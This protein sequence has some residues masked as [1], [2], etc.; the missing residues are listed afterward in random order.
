MHTHTHARTHTHAH[1]HTHMHT[2]CLPQLSELR[3]YIAIVLAMILCKLNAN[4]CNSELPTEKVVIPTDKNALGLGSFW[5][6]YKFHIRSCRQNPVPLK[7]CSLAWR[8]FL[9]RVLL[10]LEPPHHLHMLAQPILIW[11]SEGRRTDVVI[12][13]V[14]LWKLGRK[15]VSQSG[16]NI[17][18]SISSCRKESSLSAVCAVTLIASW[19]GLEIRWGQSGG[20]WLNKYSCL[21]YLYYKIL[22]NY[23]KSERWL[24]LKLLTKKRWRKICLI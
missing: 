11:M 2:S 20:K 21:Y 10:I 3:H 9:S 6:V 14:Q 13:N 22:C 16:W 24:S 23:F 4:P 1:A 18:F 5:Q 8:G 19:F 15:G 17:L 12:L 7:G